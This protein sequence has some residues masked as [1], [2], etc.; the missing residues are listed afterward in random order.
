MPIVSAPA[1]GICKGYTRARKTARQY[2]GA[3]SYDVFLNSLVKLVP[4]VTLTTSSFIE[5][6]W[7]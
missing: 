3:F 1:R 2:T 6:L 7:L 4:M 5:T